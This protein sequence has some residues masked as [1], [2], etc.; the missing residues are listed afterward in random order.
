MSV[1]ELCKA[2]L[3]YRQASCIA[4]TSLQDYRYHILPFRRYFGDDRD[5]SSITLDE[6]LDFYI[7]VRETW[8]RQGTR[9][10][11]TRGTVLLLDWFVQNYGTQALLFSVRQLPK[12]K[13]AIK[14]VHLLTDAE[15]QSMFEACRASYAWVTIRNC[16]I[17]SVT[18]G[19][20]LRLSEVVNIKTSNVNLDERYLSIIGKGSKPRYVAFNGLAEYYIR[21]YLSVCPY[22]SSKSLFHTVDGRDITAWTIKNFM[23][24][25][26][27]KTGIEFTSH[28]LRHNYTSRFVN[29]NLETRGVIGMQ[30]LAAILSHSSPKT[31]ERYVHVAMQHRSLK[32]YVDVLKGVTPDCKLKI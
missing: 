14:D 24:R 27:K 28:T 31:T 1:S 19:S 7:Y 20:A 32:S 26:R 8:K 11:Y 18:L 9:Y 12:V 2:Y 10:T 5:V 29:F 21:K 17:L 4:E 3:R 16:G 13:N 25:L 22:P 30:E 23:A 15:I 6:M